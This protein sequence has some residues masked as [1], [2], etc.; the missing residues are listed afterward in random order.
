V[1][2]FIILRRAAGPPGSARQLGARSAATRFARRRVASPCDTWRKGKPGKATAIRRAPAI[3]AVRLAIGLIRNS[4]V[5]E[6][7]PSLAR[8]SARC[9]C[10]RF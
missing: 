1:A 4:L 7:M 5:P 6:R 8:V 3:L 10:R 2:Q 9:G